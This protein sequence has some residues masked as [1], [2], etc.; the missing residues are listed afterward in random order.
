M[1]NHGDMLSGVP[2]VGDLVR[3]WGACRIVLARTPHEDGYIL[4]VKD[5]GLPIFVSSQQPVEFYRAGQS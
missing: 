5:C 2:E 1:S 4:I 3:F